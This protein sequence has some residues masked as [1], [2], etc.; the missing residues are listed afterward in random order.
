MFLQ[1]YECGNIYP[2]HEIEK[3]KKLKVDTKHHKSDNE[4]EAKEGIVMGIPKRSSPAGKKISAKK[5]R[6]RNRMHHKDPEIDRDP[7]TWRR[8]CSCRL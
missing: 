8:E 4:F 5:R 1:C 2:V 3:L 6:E 7:T